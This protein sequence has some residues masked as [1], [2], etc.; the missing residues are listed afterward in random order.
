MPGLLYGHD[1]ILV[2]FFVNNV[3]GNFNTL[4][5]R[6]KQNKIKPIYERLYLGSPWHDL[7]EI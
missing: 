7:V 3:C 4:T 6:K 1:N 5:K 2:L